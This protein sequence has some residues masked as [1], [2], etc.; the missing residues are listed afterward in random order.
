MNA[1]IYLG[2]TVGILTGLYLLLQRGMDW[3]LGPNQP[4]PPVE[5]CQC[6]QEVMRDGLEA[7]IR[8]GK[9]HTRSECE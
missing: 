7:I 5:E 6:K 4:D 9:R 1:A 8:H 2:V 3:V